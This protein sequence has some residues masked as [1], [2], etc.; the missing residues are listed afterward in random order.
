LASPRRKAEDSLDAA[1]RVVP[2]DPEDLPAV[3]RQAADSDG[4]A[5]GSS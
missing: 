3:V 4:A 5:A 1:G 2:E